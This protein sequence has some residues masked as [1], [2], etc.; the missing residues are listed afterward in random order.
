MNEK[1]TWQIEKRRIKDLVKYP[2]NPRFLKEKDAEHLKTS[3]SKFGLIDK[4]II[5]LDDQI[6][7]GHQRIGILEKM[8]EKT[9]EVYVPDRLLLPEEVE[10]LNIRLN[11]NTGDWQYDIL[12]NEFEVIDLLK[13]G[14][15][16]ENLGLTSFEGMNSE[17]KEEEKC[18]K[19]P[20]CNQKIKK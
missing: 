1:I 18:E 6:I 5:N 19:C 13:W 14:F 15:E 7:G 10:E 2:K 8:G 17:E 3:I 9:I 11:K 4:P 12:A 20:T 16:A